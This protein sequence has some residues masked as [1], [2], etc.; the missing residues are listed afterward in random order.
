[1]PEVRTASQLRDGDLVIARY[2]WL[3]R[4][5]LTPAKRIKT[6]ARMMTGRYAITYTDG[7]HERTDAGRRFLVVTKP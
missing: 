5:T 7:T 4:R 6:V 3:R 1:M 2:R